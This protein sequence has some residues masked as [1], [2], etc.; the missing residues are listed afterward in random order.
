MKK[1][2]G[3]VGLLF[4]GFGSVLA[5]SK[6]E[7][8]RMLDDVRK[9]GNDE[10]REAKQ[11]QRQEAALAAPSDFND[12]DSFGKGVNFL[13]SLYAGTV[14]IQPGCA[15]SDFPFPLAPDDKC[16]AKL[17]G[18]SSF[19]VQNLYDPAWELTIPGKS[20]KNVIYLLI[21]NTVQFDNGD[22][23]G[24]L[25]GGSGLLSYSPVVELR[26]DAL[27]DP[28]AI[29]PNTGLPMNGVFATSLPGA[30]IDAKTVV[31]N[32]LF[33]EVRSYGS[34]NGRGFSR[35]YFRA[36]GLPENVIDSIYKKDLKLRFGIRAGMSGPFTTA[37]F[38]YQFRVLGQ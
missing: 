36:L 33:Q 35:S 17:V 9:A 5:Q 11:S 15:A 20:A 18:G 21:N 25:I 1:V 29:N 3:I 8:K 4:L 27:L 10:I 38:F 13:G 22:P 34:V 12:T 26:S 2:L 23:N 6:A 16:I 30:F 32:Q 7:N 28:A 14:Y 19:P 31:A 24:G 37:A